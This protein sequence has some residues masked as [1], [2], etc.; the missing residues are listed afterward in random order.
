MLVLF[1]F[2]LLGKTESVNYGE[3]RILKYQLADKEEKLVEKFRKNVEEADKNESDSGRTLCLSQFPYKTVTI[4]LVKL[5][6]FLA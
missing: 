3:E 2:H 5:V 1:L 6:E 4:K